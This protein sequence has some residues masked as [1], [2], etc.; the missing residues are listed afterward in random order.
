MLNDI[1]KLAPPLFSLGLLRIDSPSSS[2]NKEAY[3]QDRQFFALHKKR[4]LYIRGS[5]AGEFDLEMSVEDLLLVPRLHVLVTQ[6][7]TGI[8]QVTPIYR[9]ADFYYGHD[10]TDG[11][12][13][14]IVIEMA[15]RNG[16]DASEFATYATENDKRIKASQSAV[17]HGAIN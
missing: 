8:H 17:S 10:G 1:Y 3:A 7:A 4:S 15:R 5:Y 12:I 16:I 13:V 2:H 14:Q 6:L 9:G 11:E